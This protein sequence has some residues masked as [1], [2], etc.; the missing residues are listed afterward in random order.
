[1]ERCLRTGTIVRLLAS[2]AL[3]GDP[4][5]PNRNE[6]IVTNLY[7]AGLGFLGFLIAILGLFAGGSVE[8]V[9]VGLVALFAAGTLEAFTR[10]RA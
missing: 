9:I 8:L 3:H 10:R 1:M 4:G 2:I 5:L 7:A 6:G